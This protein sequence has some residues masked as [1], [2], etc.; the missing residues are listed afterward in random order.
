M[1]T[2]VALA[3]S[4]NAKF[5]VLFAEFTHKVLIWVDLPALTCESLHFGCVRIALWKV[6]NEPKVPIVCPLLGI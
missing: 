4:L 3:D 6:F 2:L 5:F 1:V